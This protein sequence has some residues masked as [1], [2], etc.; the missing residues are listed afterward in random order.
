MK[1]GKYK[2]K[3]VYIAE[4]SLPNMSAYAV[5]VL[6][7]C[8]SL[9]KLG[10]EVELILPYIDKSYKFNKIKDDYLLKYK[11]CS[12]FN[13]RLKLNF[14]YRIIFS[15]KILFYLKKIKFNMVLSRSIIPSLVLSIFGFKNI[16]EIH[17]ELSGITS[18]IFKLTNI[19]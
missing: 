11:I 7:M 6:K 2:K 12:I 10:Y 9:S 16:L 8:D 19:I 5:H 4:F 13:S 14:I 17:T 1:T 18:H 3:I 15:F